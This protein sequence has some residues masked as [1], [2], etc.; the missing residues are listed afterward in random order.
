[1]KE[2]CMKIEKLLLNEKEAAELLNMSTHF[3]RRDRISEQS[4]GIPFLRIGGSVRYHC[5]DLENWIMEQARNPVR[6]SVKP[7]KNSADCSIEKRR[8]GR[9]RKEI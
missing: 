1:M 2:Q 5:V 9:P 4:T 8:R 3:L 6:K 7:Q